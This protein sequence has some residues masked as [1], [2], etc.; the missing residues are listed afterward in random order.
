MNRY[1]NQQLHPRQQANA[2]SNNEATLNLE[3]I[4][5]I[6]SDFK[7]KFATPRQPGLV[8]EAQAKLVLQGPYNQ[9]DAVDGL[10][11]FSHI[12]LIFG[13]HATA[14]QGWKPKVRPPRLGGNAKLGVFA[15]RSTFRPNPLGLSLVRLEK[16][17]TQQ[18]VCLHIQGADL[19]QGTPVYDI[20]PYLPWVESQPDAA[21]GFAGEAQ[22]LDL[23]VNFSAPAEAY[24]Q[25]KPQLRAL[26]AQV[27]KHDPRPAYQQQDDRVYGCLLQQENVQWQVLPEQILVTAISP[28]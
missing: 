22:T 2:M 10:E 5:Y 24:L 17:T 4:G 21:S 7:E 25:T 19:I 20:K 8:T 18:G 27:L 1:C 14:E 9:A 13:F 11:A 3:P 28:A 16:I 23:P 6:E 26:I 12:W 15:T